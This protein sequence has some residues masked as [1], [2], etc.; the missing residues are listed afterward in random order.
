MISF[1]VP[2]LQRYSTIS[3]FPL[4]AAVIRHVSSHCSAHTS[5][6]CW[7]CYVEH[8]ILQGFSSRQYPFCIEEKK[9]RLELTLFC[10]MI[11]FSPPNSQRYSTTS[12]FPSP[13]AVIRH[14]SSHCSAQT[15]I[16]CW[17]CYQYCRV[18]QPRQYPICIYV[19]QHWYWES[20]VCCLDVY[21]NLRVCCRMQT[22]HSK[23][24]ISSS[25][26]SHRHWTISKDNPLLIA[27]ATQLWPACTP[28]PLNILSNRNPNCSLQ[29][30]SHAVAYACNYGISST[31]WNSIPCFVESSDLCH[32]L[33]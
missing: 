20:K 10:S 19:K 27:L 25:T 32:L 14:V 7:S 1:S 24:R 5:I 17:S 28:H 33:P 8:T 4:P 3:R 16:I 29:L 26:S 31:Y 12:R 22:L 15:S 21:D 6:I 11:S 18:F 30:L 2:N 23:R 9:Y 13:A